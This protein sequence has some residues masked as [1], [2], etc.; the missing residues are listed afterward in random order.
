MSWCSTIG[1]NRVSLGGC[2]NIGVLVAYL[3]YSPSDVCS[4]Q[5]NSGL[6]R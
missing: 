6:Q 4:G 5:M 1:Y 2:S 3:A